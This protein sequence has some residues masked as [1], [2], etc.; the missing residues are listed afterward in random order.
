MQKS[1]NGKRKKA[2][3]SEVANLLFSCLLEKPKADK[4]WNENSFLLWIFFQNFIFDV[5][6]FIEWFYWRFNFIRFSIEDFSIYFLRLFN[7]FYILFNQTQFFRNFAI[8]VLKKSVKLSRQD[9]DFLNFLSLVQMNWEKIIFGFLLI[10][11]KILI[12]LIW[13]NQKRSSTIGCLIS[14]CVKSYTECF[15]FG[16][17]NSIGISACSWYKENQKL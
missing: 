8:C 6:N 16:T 7:L 2:R 13:I 4:K 14:W 11:I 10:L 9:F 15:F 12:D 5:K 1:K 17:W 3:N